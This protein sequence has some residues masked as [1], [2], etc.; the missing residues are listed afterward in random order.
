MTCALVLPITLLLTLFLALS[1][2]YA[3]YV[4]ERDRVHARIMR[5][6]RREADDQR[7]RADHLATELEIGEGKRRTLRKALAHEREEQEADTH[8]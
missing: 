2:A 6:A 5:K 8:A 4:L 7:K 1:I 3:R